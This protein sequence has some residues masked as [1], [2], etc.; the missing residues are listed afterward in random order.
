MAVSAS[1]GTTG[2]Q[3]PAG[4][5]SCRLSCWQLLL[6][7]EGAQVYMHQLSLHGAVNVT[8]H[9]SYWLSKQRGP[10]TAHNCLVDRWGMGRVAGW[11]SRCH[12][13]GGTT[14][15]PQQRQSANRHRDAYAAVEQ[16]GWH[17]SPIVGRVPCSV[18]EAVGDAGASSFRCLSSARGLSGAAAVYGKGG[19]L[20]GRS[21]P[22]NQNRLHQPRHHGV[23]IFKLPAAA[24]N[25]QCS[26]AGVHTR[27]SHGPL[28]R[29]PLSS[30]HAIII[31][32]K[33]L[34]TLDQHL[35][36]TACPASH[37][38]LNRRCLH[39]SGQH[40]PLPVQTELLH[41]FAFPAPSTSLVVQMAGA[42]SCAPPSSLACCCNRLE[43][44]Q[45]KTGVWVHC[46][47]SLHALARHVM[48]QRRP[49]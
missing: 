15:Q 49:P 34:P 33:R 47:P 8:K 29:I 10:A 18:A 20:P 12:M 17:R 5:C 3:G 37:R 40:C 39:T 21:G 27:R 6:E 26:A 31:I 23:I 48:Q 42:C 22:C 14:P 41:L 45:T 7:R 32:I 4:F 46:M 13:F 30:P 25:Q 44:Y 24:F 43:Q 19:G 38:R 9:G 1:D 16:H 28:K 2:D 35:R 11:Q 36:N